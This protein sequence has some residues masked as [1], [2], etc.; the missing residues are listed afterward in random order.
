M[1]QTTAIYLV[2]H[3]ETTAN[4]SN[5][6]QGQSDVP[7]NEQGLKQAA[8]IGARLRE[9]HFDFIASSDLS[10]A[11]VTA[12]EI[13]GEREIFFTPLLRRQ[14]SRPGRGGRIC[15]SGRGSG[16]STG[17]SASTTGQRYQ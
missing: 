7:L 2:R 9:K 6:L 3:G 12:R 1:E 11:A 17:R 16:V 5:V 10:R 14:G 8:L 4:V 15:R 13:A